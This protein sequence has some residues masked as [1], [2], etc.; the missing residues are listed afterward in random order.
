MLSRRNWKLS[1]PLAGVLAV[2]LIAAFA[3]NDSSN[4]VTGPSVDVAPAG[5]VTGAWSGTFHSDGACSSVPITAS[6][7][8]SGSAVTGHIATSGCGLDGHFEGTLHGNIFSGTVK[9][10]GCTGGTVSGSFSSS[11]LDFQV[12][13]MVK[14]PTVGVDGIVSPGGNVTMHR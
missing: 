2:G 6:F 14:S 9:M 3:C 4:M 8:Q 13:E 12:G 11:G 1:L 5:D 7:A 10:M